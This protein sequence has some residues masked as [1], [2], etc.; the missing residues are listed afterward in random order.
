MSTATPVFAEPFDPRLDRRRNVKIRIHEKNILL[1]DRR[2]PESTIAV[3]DAELD[4]ATNQHQAACEPIQEEIAAVE[5]QRCEL[6]ADGKVVPDSLNLRRAELLEMLRNENEKLEAAASDHR[7][8]T[9]VLKRDI[10]AINE[11]LKRYSD[12]TPYSLAQPDVANPRLADE[13]WVTQRACEFCNHRVRA[14]QE[15]IQGY[16]SE[17]A[18][19]RNP[20][21]LVAGVGTIGRNGEPIRYVDSDTIA[22]YQRRLERWRLE[23]SAAGDALA[24]ANQEAE[25]ARRKIID[26]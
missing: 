12:L 11:K 7:D 22:T 8:R 23:L 21:Q 6:L 2:K 25:V 9:A 5:R 13:H 3:L 20:R 15:K 26:E 1:D 24:K 16:E 10:K 14:A 18:R 4:T 19:L 17:I